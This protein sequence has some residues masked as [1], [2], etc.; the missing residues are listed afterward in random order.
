MKISP[1]NFGYG[2]TRLKQELI[3]DKMTIVTRVRNLSRLAGVSEA[4]P[5]GRPQTKSR[6]ER[7]IGDKIW[8]ARRDD[9]RT[10]GDP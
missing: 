6:A 8:C 3:R 1:E 4:E 5:S 2:F 9:F 10:L 7:G